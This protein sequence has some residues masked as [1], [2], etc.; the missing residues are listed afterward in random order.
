MMNSPNFFPRAAALLLIC[1]LLLTACSDSVDA[2][3][4]ALD[5][6]TS[7]EIFTELNTQIMLI[8]FSQTAKNGEPSDDLRA[9]VLEDIII[10]NTAACNGGGS[11]TVTGTVSSNSFDNDGNGTFGYDLRQKPESCRISTNQG[12][13]SVDGD[14]E[15]RVTAN[16]D[17]NEWEPVGMFEFGYRGG[18]TW[19]GSGSS[20][21]CQINMDYAFNYSTNQMSMKGHMCGYQIDV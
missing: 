1:P 17:Y 18:Y 14:P 13:F 5:Q 15:I 10:N 4:Q 11:I 2:G 21:G 9:A 20:G 3:D 12:T 19:S 16:I 8:A 6:A 7:M